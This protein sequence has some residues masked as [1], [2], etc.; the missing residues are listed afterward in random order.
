MRDMRGGFGERKSMYVYEVE[1]ASIKQVK[2]DLDYAWDSRCEYASIHARMIGDVHLLVI[3]RFLAVMTKQAIRS[4]V[5][6]KMAR[7][8]QR[9]A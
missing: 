9:G 4:L 6:I 8:F 3:R 1:V 5:T 7:Y 2:Y